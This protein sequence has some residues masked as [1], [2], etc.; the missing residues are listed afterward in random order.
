MKRELSSIMGKKSDK[1]YYIGLDIG[2]D[3]I[4][5]A[6]TDE[7]YNLIKVHGKDYW[8]SY[9]FEEA[10]TAQE[11][12]IFRTARRRLARVRHRLMLLQ[13]LFSEEMAKVDPT[14]FIR[15]NNSPLKV[16]D[17]NDLVKT[18]N[19]L[20]NDSDYTDK[21]YF[22]KYPTIF[23]LR[24]A[25]IEG[26]VKDIR[27]LYIAVHHIIK[28][29]GHFLYEGNDFQTGDKK[30]LKEKFQEISR[31]YSDMF[32]DSISLDRYEELFEV[33]CKQNIKKSDKERRVKEYINAGKDK[34]RISLV[35]ALVGYTFAF[36]DLFRQVDEED[37][38]DIDFGEVDKLCFADNSYDENFAKAS[39]VL[40]GDQ[41]QLILALKAIYDLAVL[42][43]IL[44]GNKY[45]SQSKV[46]DYDEHKEDLK[47]LKTYV[48]ENYPNKYEL[49]FRYP[50]KLKGNN[51]ND[52]A[53]GG[54]KE[55]VCNY[56]V[57]IG[58]DRQKSYKTCSKEDFY[59]FL[60]KELNITDERILAKMEQ[61]TFLKK[62]ISGENC[63][64]PYQVHLKE[65]H[66]ILENAKK[67]FSFLTEVSDGMT[68]V[69]KIE[70]LMTFRVPYYVGP[71]STIKNKSNDNHWIVKKQGEEKTPITPW[72]FD[73]I[74]DK[75]ESEK[76]FIAKMTNKCTYLVGEDVLPASSFL[77]SECAFLNELNNLKINGEKNQQAK[78]L[79]YEFAKKNKK[80][81]LKSCL[82]LLKENGVIEKESKKE[83]VF[84]GTDG[85]FKNSLS[86]YIDFKNII[87]DKAD[88]Y[89]EMCEQIIL[90]ITVISD[91]NRL[92]KLI[93]KTYGKILTDDEIKK[94][95]GLNYSKWG[96]FSRA[97]LTEI[98][99]FKECDCNDDG[100]PLSI[101]E[102]M[103]LS[104][105]NFMQL[106]SSQHGYSDSIIEYN[107]SN[108]EDEIVTYKTIENLYCSPAVKR[109]IWKAV[110]IVKEIEKSQ[111]H[112]PKKVFV[113][114]AREV[115]DGS[116]KGQRTKSRKQ[117]LIDLYSDIKGEE[118]DW[119]TEIEQTAD[120]KFNSD[121]IFFY[122]TQMGRDIYTGEPIS[123]DEIF[124]VNLYDIDHIYPQ[125]KIKDDSLNNR[126]LVSKYVNEHV[127]RD[128]YPLNDDIRKNR[129]AFWKKLKDN[130]LISEEKFYR[131]TR[132]KPLTK[133]ECCDFINRQLVE[134]RQSTKEVTK[135]LNK[136]LPDTEI[137]YSK[138]GNVND[139]K[140]KENMKFVKVRELNDFH[141]AKDAY[142]NIVV[143]NVYNT[144]FN[145]NASVYFKDHNI[146]SYN[147]KNLYNEDIKGAWKKGDYSRIKAIASKNTCRIVRFTN[148]GTGGLFDATIKTAGANDNLI[149]LKK[150]GA[151]S[152]TKKYGGYDS[153]TTA[154]F[155]LV[156]S[157]GK[158][159]EELLSLEAI[160]ILADKGFSSMQDKV[161][162]CEE[163][164]KLK[165][166]EI[167]IDKIKINTLFNINGS[168]AYI[169]G[170]TGP[171]ILWCNANELIIDDESERYLKKISNCFKD[172]KKY[173]RKELIIGEEINAESNSRLYDVLTE[174][175]GSKIYSGLSISK[176]AEF[177]VENKDKFINLSLEDQ[178][179]VLFEI[180]KFM[181][182]NSV[183]SDLTKI[184]G[185]K[186]EGNLRL[187]KNIKDKQVK[188]IL[189]SP[190]GLYKK[191][192]NIS[193][194]EETSKEPLS[195]CNSQKDELTNKDTTKL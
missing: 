117:Q 148:E 171:S 79:I 3:S 9:L 68:V 42:D 50:K 78:T 123:L 132:N 156:R 104:N 47:W 34:R 21:D 90:W 165:N 157:R 118:R 51:E 59:K 140:N 32:D 81:T 166:P 71:L 106:L 8:G 95:K 161:K 153:A 10:K 63:V 77:Y 116:R 36:K 154:Y 146:D 23:H 135:I 143:G 64:I 53:D 67:H 37:N 61:G 168:Y 31:I 72:N 185:S 147:L 180:L 108:E 98:K 91:K 112:A 58:M 121:K 89:S 26:E 2:T 109:S 144:K 19:V 27:L 76:A 119:I 187:N 87:G 40:D 142:F 158:K 82:N 174:K 28:S 164:L 105:E 181:Q 29:R 152:D 15:L 11:R 99:S 130:K 56:A 7:D 155:M 14:F 86:S 192:V 177:L 120:N 179:V 101:I 110:N 1:N 163:K 133:D 190:T 172:K 18:K 92:E 178:C 193:L 189:Q 183:F 134:T 125:S 137:V 41:Q 97:L 136:L 33:L 6:V 88:T 17:K 138:A 66:A 175:L 170:K 69:E 52:Q 150:N 83:D 70:K 25:L 80:V 13:S 39:N 54:K 139:F 43:N 114:M 162:F 194:G 107:N 128:E 111:G 16:E 22:K 55:K 5:W 186:N 182:C 173:N 35:K 126:V 131:L 122:Y 113:E 44:H 188:M 151:I 45:L 195:H 167:V 84:S 103:R 93:K 127:K 4:G 176:K 129:I 169:R 100:E 74:V 38:K 48:R 60:K 102:K 149:P 96:R 49:V 141:H 24:K 20:F 184:G 75:D 159:G 57:Y 46:N 124:N 115:D 65:L 85:D 94:I 30:L 145:H 160:S 62:Q 73:E 191:V 12:R